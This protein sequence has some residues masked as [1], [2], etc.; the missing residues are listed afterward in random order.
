MELVTETVGEA[1]RGLVH[2]DLNGPACGGAGESE[3]ENPELVTC[4]AC[5]DILGDVELFLA[6][7]MVREDSAAREARRLARANQKTD[8][9]QSVSS[10][11]GKE[12]DFCEALAKVLEGYGFEVNLDPK[13]F[14]GSDQLAISIRRKSN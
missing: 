2:C 10:D 8:P 12:D 9:W 6:T 13:E 14:W 7:A 1:T 3:S 4:P 11:F 5:L